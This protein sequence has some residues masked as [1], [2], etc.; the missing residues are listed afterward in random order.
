MNPLDDGIYARGQTSEGARE[1]MRRLALVAP[2]DTKKVSTDT[3]VQWIRP[4]ESGVIASVSC[5]SHPI[6]S[7]MN[8]RQY[9]W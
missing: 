7:E 3:I 8:N 4:Y 2:T 6:E 5:V 9:F 1:P